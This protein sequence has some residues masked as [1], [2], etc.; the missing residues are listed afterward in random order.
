MFRY[1]RLNTSKARTL[2]KSNFSARKV[3]LIFGIVSSALAIVASSMTILRQWNSQPANS[4]SDSIA[5]SQAT[6]D[7]WK[8]TPKK[9]EEI[10]ATQES[11]KEPAT[12]SSY[13]RSKA[14]NVTSQKR[15]QQLGAPDNRFQTPYNFPVPQVHPSWIAA[16][17]MPPQGSRL[18]LLNGTP[19]LENIDGTVSYIRNTSRPILVDKVLRKCPTA[20][21]S[22]NIASLRN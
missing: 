9:S 11:G 1:F 15:S 5:P 22:M 8:Q 12:Q 19:F 7:E 2:H 14:Q 3:L 10:V 21:N 6:P 4:G 20:L 17:A 13:T 18:C 16:V